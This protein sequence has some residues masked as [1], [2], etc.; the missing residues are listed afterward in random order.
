MKKRTLSVILSVIML[1]SMIPTYSFT[2]FADDEIS[3]GTIGDIT[4]TLNVTT[5]ALEIAGTGE[6]PD[7]LPPH[8]CAPWGMLMTSVVIGDG[9]TRIGDG[10]FRYCRSL[11]DVT[12][13]QSVTSIGSYAF[14]EC[15]SLANIHYQG[16]PYN[17]RRITFSDYVFSRTYNLVYPLVTGTLPGTSIDY[18]IDYN[19]KT[20]TLTG[21]GAIPDYLPPHIGA[22]WTGTDDVETVVIGDGITRIGNQ[23]FAY[24]RH[25]TSITIPASVTSLGDYVFYECTSFGNI[26][27]QGTPNQW[28]NVAKGEY[29]YNISNVHY[30]PLTG[31][32][33]QNVTFS[34]D[35]ENGI[36]TFS[37]SGPMFNYV[38][39][40]Y[41][42]PWLAYANLIKHIIIG[43]G[44][45]NIGADM[46]YNCSDLKSIVIPASVTG[47]ETY[48]FYNCPSSIDVLY[49]GSAEQWAQ[50]SIVDIENNALI[51]GVKHYGI[52]PGDTY[53]SFADLG[54]PGVFWAIDHSAQ[55][56]L[57]F[58]TGAVPSIP[59]EMYLDG[60]IVSYRYLAPWTG[61][62]DGIT[63]VAVRD[64]ITSFGSAS[65]CY[66]NDL[67]SV[68][69]GKDVGDISS[70]VFGGAIYGIKEFIVSPLNPNLAS[71]DGVLY[72]K[73]MTR[74]KWYPAAK[75]DSLFTVPNGV[76]DIS[77]AFSGN[78]YIESIDMPD[79]VTTI[80]SAFQSLSSLK[81]IRISAGV[82]SL[83][84]ST[85]VMCPSLRTLYLPGGLTNIETAAVWGSYAD[86]ID[87]YF[88]GTEEEWSA[89]TIGASNNA[90]VNANMHFK[91]VV[92]PGLEKVDA[93]T[94]KLTG[95]DFSKS[96]TIRYATGEYDTVGAVKNGTNAGFMQ[97]SGAAE[98]VIE[99][100]THG[101]HT[102]A[103][104]SGGETEFLGTVEIVEE[105]MKNTLAAATDDI[106]VN[107]ENLYGASQVRLIQNGAVL[108]KVNASQFNSDG[109]R[110]SAT[111]AAPSEGTYTVAVMYAD[112]TRLSGDITVTVPHAYVS[113][114]GRLFTVIDY[115]AGNVSYMRLAKG[116]IATTAEMKAA[117]DLRT[118]GAKYFR[119]DTSA[120][121]ALDAFAPETYTIQIGYVSGY[122]EFITF[123]IT[124]TWPTITGGEG[125]ITVDRA[126]FGSCYIDWIRCAPG[127][128]DSLYAIRHARG[129]QIKKTRDI[130][131]GKILF[132]GLEPGV[133]TL[134]YL[135]DANNLS[136]GM[137]TVT[138][139]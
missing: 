61:K 89:V 84:M 127:Q 39:P 96:Y 131:D 77:G 118:Y 33:G 41:S 55:N 94:V 76:Y 129:S 66:L 75:E 72:N 86:P 30:P 4:W 32:C 58:G 53:G 137:V 60:G 134:Y 120:F 116:E 10:A 15:D 103:A 67:E 54:N 49:A 87:I 14:N 2:A 56:M 98:A 19:T 65:L 122:T 24:C 23:S 5:G 44:I 100:P 97:I 25:L 1:L 125:T 64:G 21:T 7:Y 68:V 69:L 22:P 83:P 110:Y 51:Y 13:P 99:L 106:Y 38:V 40:H 104:V 105:D 62:T 95:L 36:L 28:D 117:E 79:T 90:V 112:G 74:L 88:D 136:E 59:Q 124:P 73:G 6:I 85:I 119:E 8:V 11:T 71:V 17:W 92:L 91:E 34:L 29:N 46:F 18:E 45:T 9:I 37:G 114:S 123:S 57:V 139:R 126:S 101:V 43:D 80:N 31:S 35:F 130:V 50:V 113:T 128:L 108:L 107:V 48:A 82:T 102:V 12:I 42:M 111:F 70:V 93:Y 16:N 109:L 20:L 26:Y 27:Y 81:N 138:V 115:G 135:Y 132:T 52:V 78:P 133:Y 47:V 121:V 3:T 63:N